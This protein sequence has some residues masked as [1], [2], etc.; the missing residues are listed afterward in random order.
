MRRASLKTF[1]RVGLLALLLVFRPSPAL[2]DDVA[3]SAGEERATPLPE[4]AK[5]YFQP[6]VEHQWAQGLV[7]GVIDE[8][9]THVFGFGRKGEKQP[10]VPDGDTVFEIGSITKVFTGTLLADMAE[11]GLVNIDDP[12]NKLLPETIG[13]LE[14]GGREMR[15]VD[16]ATHTSG[17]PRLP[18]NLD[19]T[20]LSDPY[21]KYTADDLLE[22][23]K[24][25]AQ[26]S[27][28]KSLAASLKGLFGTQSSQ[29]WQYSNLGVGL[30][31]NLL[32][33]KASQPYEELVVQRICRPLHM[34]STRLTLDDSMAARL[35]GGHDADGNAVKNWQFGCLAPCGG[36]HSTANDMLKLLAADLDMTETPLKSA[37]AKMQQPHFTVKPELEMGLNWLIL[38]GDIVFHDGMTGGYSSL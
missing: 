26:P 23:L 28:T 2:A 36:L 32:E 9:G 35:I 37:L 34:D 5:R 31:G 13:R 38:K 14:C 29:G 33:R 3:K 1:G 22:F 25:H 11:R 20:D 6:L 19:L 7:V 8:R 30:L 21:A 10:A 15:L 16:L 4:L 17:L 18:S 24:Q 12:V 27:L